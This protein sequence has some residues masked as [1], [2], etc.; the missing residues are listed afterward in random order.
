VSS[1]ST[2][3]ANDDDDSGI[4]LENLT[5]DS[6]MK[7]PPRSLKQRRSQQPHRTSFSSDQRRRP[8]RDIDDVIAHQLSATADESSYLCLCDCNKDG[9]CDNGDCISASGSKQVLVAAGNADSEASK[10]PA[11]D[12]VHIPEFQ[13]GDTNGGGGVAVTTSGDDKQAH[14]RSHNE[15]T[16]RRPS[17]SV[18]SSQTM[19]H[20]RNWKNN[21]YDDDDD[22]DDDD[23]RF[24][25]MRRATKVR[26]VCYNGR[27]ASMIDL[28]GCDAG[29]TDRLSC[30][31]TSGPRAF[32]LQQQGRPSSR[33]PC[34]AAGDSDE[35]MEK[36]P[37][38]QQSSRIGRSTAERH[39]LVTCGRQ[40]SV[41]ASAFRRSMGDLKLTSVR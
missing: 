28:T 13:K 9:D 38:Q 33:L 22:Y 11:G 24:F 27:L 4:N 29:L 17:G 1:S 15:V 10:T 6:R 12:A 34:P 7:L 37:P 21:Q 3:V 32:Q 25:R 39:Q 2:F 18:R 16:I 14:R 8:L 5:M 26:S 40:P 41:A 30:R 35:M 20:R 31:A 36:K 19:D 23:A